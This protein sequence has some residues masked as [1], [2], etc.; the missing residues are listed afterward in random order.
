MSEHVISGVLGLVVL[1]AAG[2]ML[3]EWW[4]WG[5]KR[6]LSRRLDEARGQERRLNSEVAELKGMLE[7]AMELAER[8]PRERARKVGT[9]EIRRAFLRMDPQHPFYQGLMGLLAN[10]TALELEAATRPDLTDGGR[11]FNAGRLAMAEDVQ[12]LIVDTMVEAREWEQR[13]NERLAREARAEKAR[14]PEG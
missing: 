8:S 13:E 6:Q 4:N 2:A 12:Q 9:E 5:E 3:G 11:H 1:L 10:A 14:N 7:R